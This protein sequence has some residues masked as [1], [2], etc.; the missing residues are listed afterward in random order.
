MIPRLKST[1]LRILSPGRASFDRITELVYLGSRHRKRARTTTGLRDAGVRA[2]VD[3]KR[4]GADLW[5]FEA[6]LW[7]PTVDHEAPNPL[8][9]QM[10]IS[11]LRRCEEAATP[12][13]VHCMVGVGRSATL[14][15][16]H[17]LAGRFRGAQRRGGPGLPRL[18]PAR[19]RAQ[20][21]ADRGRGGSG[22]RLLGLGPVD[23]APCGVGIR[24]R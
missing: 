6:F 9:L 21:P 11:F 17:L 14:V 4:E 2:S 22:A 15:L 7:L 8:H 5:T 24:P 12:V 23:P 19:G 18:A 3:L 1:S 20:H 13:F 10:G 16:A